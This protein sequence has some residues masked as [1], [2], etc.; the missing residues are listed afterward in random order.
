[1][2]S[3]LPLAAQ[4]IYA[5]IIDLC[6][7]A[8]FDAAFPPNGSFIATTVKGRR[9]WYYQSGAKDAS[10][11]QSKKYVGPDNEHNAQL[12]ARHGAAKSSYRQRRS[13]VAALKRFGLPGPADE[14]G[15]ILRGLADHGVFRLRACVIGTVAYQ[16]YCGLLGVK[17]PTAALQT[18]DLDLAQ[19]RAISVAIA[20]DEKTLAILDIL[21]NIDPTFRAAP[22]LSAP[23]VAANYINGANYR[24]EILTDNRGPESDRPALL[25][26]LRTHAQPLCFLDYLLLDAIPAAVLWDGGV[27]VNVP[28]AE[29]YAVHKLI[30]AQRRTATAA[31]RPKDLL[32]ASALFDALAE[33]RPT[34]LAAAWTE[35]Y[36]RGPK[37]R[38]PLQAALPQL[39]STGRDRL[40][41]AIGQT[42]SF[43]AGLDIEF[44][45]P[46]PRYDFS[47]D[48][49]AFVGGIA[50]Q[51]KECVIS[52]EA[53]D[54]WFDA[55]GKGQESYLRAFCQHRT[56]IQAMARELYLNEKVPSD[57]A[58]LIKTTDVQ[59][60][61]ARMK[62]RA[63][64]KLR[65]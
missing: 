62:S 57:G 39:D 11:R 22:D 36:D 28:K 40:L 23:N 21:Q 51:Q 9:Y 19:S 8:D 10:G 41:Y 37:W 24:V 44:R 63:R 32:Q 65:T 52:R 26:A 18:G 54:D 27:L 20:K 42:R 47:R 34:D 61:R 15:K 2:P 17:L 60:L 6:A 31:K 30:V 13:I 45:D 50:N 4:T 29:R 59:Q 5:E 58:V 43:V 49:V 38:R 55:E 7:M 35:A 53:L 56:E 3:L 46:R 64:H 25:P 14:A 16:T 1:M 48:V 33:R 12:V